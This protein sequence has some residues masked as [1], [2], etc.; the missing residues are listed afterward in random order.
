MENNIWSLVLEKGLSFAL[1]AIA[2]YVLWK[3]RDK[4]QEAQNKLIEKNEKLQEIRINERLEMLSHLESV[5][6]GLDLLTKKMDELKK[7]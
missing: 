3:E 2:V 4:M 7:K 1:L 5:R 6:E